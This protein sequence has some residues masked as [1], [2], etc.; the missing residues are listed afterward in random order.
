MHSLYEA[1][2]LA[3]GTVTIRDER[4]PRLLAVVLDVDREPIWNPAWTSTA[5]KRVF[6]IAGERLFRSLG[7]PLLGAHHG[8]M[9]EGLALTL[10][11]RAVRHHAPASLEVLWLIRDRPSTGWGIAPAPVHCPGRNGTR[12]A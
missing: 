4:P 2:P 6:A 9:P 3:P 11:C 12:P 7:L 8:D 1:E 10:L 5:L